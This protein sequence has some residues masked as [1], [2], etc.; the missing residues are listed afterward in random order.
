LLACALMSKASLLPAQT[1]AREYTLDIARLP[2]IA[3][4]KEFSQQTGLQVG[5]FPDVRT[6][7]DTIVGPV[8]GQ[9]SLET[10]LTRLLAAS[11]LTFHRVN[12]RTV[13]VIAPWQGKAARGGIGVADNTEKKPDFPHSLPQSSPAPQED[14]LGAGAWLTAYQLEEILVT[15]S[16]LERG[17]QG[18]GPITVFSRR[19]IDELGVSTASDI[20]R[21]VPQQPYVR[22]E[23][24]R[25]DGAQFIDLRGLGLDATLILINGRRVAPSATSAMSNA[26][27]VN[28]IPLAAVERV[29]VLSDSASAIY[30]ADAIGGVVNFILKKN[31]AQPE[32]ELKYGSADGG[33]AERSVA[34]SGGYSNERVH[35]SMV[36]SYF[37]RSLLMG[38]ERDRS[39]NQDFRRFGGSDYRSTFAN[40]ANITSSTPA[41]LPG[42]PSRIAAVPP[43][44]TGVGLTPADFLPTAG[45]Q[46]RE[47][48][49]RFGSLVPDIDRLGATTFAEFLIAPRLSAFAELLY[50]DR[51][52][53][54]MV[55][56]ATLNATVPATNAF[57]P[58]GTAVNVNYLFT[59]LGSRE[60]H[61][62]SEFLRTV[63]GLRGGLGSW[64]WEFS[65]LDT[66]DDAASWIENDVSSTRVTTALAASDPAQALNV[67]QAGPGGSP[68]LLASLVAR[69]TVNTYSVDATQAAGFFRGSPFSLRAG[70]VDLVLGG[71]W[72][73]ESM[74]IRDMLQVSDDRQVSAAFAELRVP[75]I[76]AAN[77]RPGIKD[78]VAT[79]AARFDRYSDFG[80]SFNPQYGLVWTPLASLR[81][82]AS[83]G[84][85][86]RPPSLSELYAPKTAIPGSILDPRRNQVTVVTFI[87]GGNPDLDATDGKSSTV[88]FVF[89]PIWVPGLQIAGN[90]WRA[91]MSSRVAIFPPSLLLANEARYSNRIVRSPTPAEVAAGLPGALSVIDLSRLNFGE[92]ET[93][94]IDLSAAYSWETGIGRFTSDLSATWVH[95]YESI[96]F[97]ATPAVDR[98]GIASPLGTIPRW[99]AQSTIG[100]ASGWGLG[101]SATVRH[102]PSYDDLNAAGVTRRRV[103]SQT[104]VDLQASLSLE[105]MFGEDSFWRGLKLSAGVLNTFDEEPPFA[106]NGFTYGYDASQDD[107]EGRFG[108]F[109]VTK[110]F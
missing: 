76:T 65:L 68:A 62:E 48:L 34:L 61:N 100:W 42:L 6:D 98:V 86:F 37:G 32:L 38:S 99:H 104:M 19:K 4:L 12:D 1:T 45:Q 78:L 28:T 81:L 58:F 91:E 51:E 54:T 70:T 44:S 18:P 71:E 53:V 72:R 66:Q 10:A 30:G 9:Y 2:L 24:Y 46:N 82:R 43:G 85:S 21:Y 108:Y 89:S 40:P 5:Y 79:L 77:Q 101:L 55:E 63:V 41:N 49:S 60:R 20:F 69:P 7:G 67:F 92:L 73:E 96:N 75:L 35:A 94:G 64:D 105:S 22:S 26:F 95:E 17:G 87:A 29:E 56:P 33:G 36:L 106:E 110:S 93:N 14:D 15:G 109:K 25:S 16:R 57:N 88:G 27:D 47:S 102:A 80:D 103:E 31:I 74:V 23:G 90:Y 97:P 107:L 39:R 83:Y 50:A 84:T 59:G 8:R 52:T 11:G 13:A 3:A